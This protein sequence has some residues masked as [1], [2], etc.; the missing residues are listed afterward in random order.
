MASEETTLF[1]QRDGNLQSKAVKGAAELA[2]ARKD[3]WLPDEEL[4]P[5]PKPVAVAKPVVPEPAKAKPAAK[6]GRKPAKKAPKPA[7]T[8]PAAVKPD[9]KDAK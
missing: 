5:T 1:R 4:F 7:P 6:R 3:G 9:K 8:K 2:M